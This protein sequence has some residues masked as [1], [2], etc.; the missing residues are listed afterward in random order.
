MDEIIYSNLTTKSEIPEI[1]AAGVNDRCGCFY[2]R[3]VYNNI[4]NGTMEGAGYQGWFWN[5]VNLGNPDCVTSFGSVTSTSCPMLSDPTSG[6]GCVDYPNEIPGGL[7][8]DASQDGVT[9]AYACPP[10]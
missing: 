3:C 2:L 9:I 7:F 5:I 4:P 8:C 10:S 1:C 6:C